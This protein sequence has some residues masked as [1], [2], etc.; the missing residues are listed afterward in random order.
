MDCTLYILLAAVFVAD[1]L[2]GEPPN[3][4]HPVAWF[5]RLAALTEKLFRKLCGNGVLSGALAWACLTLPIPLLFAFLT[6][7]AE[8]RSRWGGFA[9]GVLCCYF[10]VALRSLHDHGERIRRPLL[11]GDLTAARRALAMIVSRDTED[12]SGSEIVRGAV[13]S[14]GEN[15]IDAVT[16][17]WFWIVAGY[18]VRGLPGAVFGA[19]FLRTVNTLDACWG[20][21]NERYG[22]FGRVAARTDDAVHFI[23]AR[24]TLLAIALSAP[25]VKGRFTETLRIGWR[26]RH[27]HPSPNSG[28]GMAGFAGAL[29]IRL[30]GPT[31]YG[32]EVENYP[33]W[34]DGRKELLPG[35]LRRAEI[36]AWAASLIFL[37]I[38]SG[39]YLLWQMN[40]S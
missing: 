10:C 24:L 12:L 3:A 14:V 7:F 11:R 37:L 36:L 23:P 16:S 13:E 6:A 5:G 33:F 30:G 20:Y 2:L 9:L 35:D 21:K 31:V 1:A 40:F 34:G 8:N 29:K 27:D 4:W 22:R 15:L 39:V 38:L 18:A 32:G 28:Y 26:H 17:A 25:L 19:L